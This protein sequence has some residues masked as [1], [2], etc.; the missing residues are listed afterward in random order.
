MPTSRPRP[1]ARPFITPGANAAGSRASVS[2]MSVSSAA[3]AKRR[4]RT[5]EAT[6]ETWAESIAGGKV[7]ADGTDGPTARARGALEI[8]GLAARGGP[9]RTGCRP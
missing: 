3:A 6:S 4:M 5:V 7:R 9:V 1:N 2:A 8:P